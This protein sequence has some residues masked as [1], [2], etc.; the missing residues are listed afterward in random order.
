MEPMV[1]PPPST[2]TPLAERARRCLGRRCL[3][4][5]C[6]GRRCLARRRLAQRASLVRRRSA[7][8][9]SYIESWV[10]AGVVPAIGS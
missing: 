5:R 3:E 1:S 4:R 6:L 7:F 2:E 9:G 8:R 10:S